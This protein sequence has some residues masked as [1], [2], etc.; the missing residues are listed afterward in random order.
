MS[1]RYRLDVRRLE[2][3]HANLPGAEEFVPPVVGAVFRQI[4]PNYVVREVFATRREEIREKAAALITEK[5]GRDAILVSDPGQGGSRRHDDGAH[6]RTELLRDEIF[7]A[8]MP[9][10]EPVAPAPAAQKAVVRR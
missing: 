10:I 2:H 5:L 8:A 6:G 1:V 7:R 9:A 3:V 4:L